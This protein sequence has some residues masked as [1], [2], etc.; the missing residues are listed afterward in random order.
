MHQFVPD[1]HDSSHSSLSRLLYDRV[2]V[3]W[4]LY[5]IKW[6]KL[7]LKDHTQTCNWSSSPAKHLFESNWSSISLPS[8][9]AS[10]LTLHSA[11]NTPHHPLTYSII[12]GMR[13]PSPSQYP[14]EI[15][16]INFVCDVYPIFPHHHL[17]SVAVPHT[18]SLPVRESVGKW[19][20]L[21][22]L[23]L[24]GR[25]IYSAA[26]CSSAPTQSSGKRNTWQFQFNLCRDRSGKF[27]TPQSSLVIHPPPA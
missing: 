2:P 16:I 27:F 20:W 1:P 11:T 9:S 4:S 21:L 15:I 5:V 23:L 12:S 7:L 17:M 24:W 19:S 14:V 3:N 10:P 25:R 18:Q 8:I 26:G 6:Y 22:L 13:R